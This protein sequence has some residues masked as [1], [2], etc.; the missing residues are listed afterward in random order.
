MNNWK[1]TTSY[2]KDDQDRVPVSWSIMFGKVRLTVT[3]DHIYHTGRWVMIAH[4]FVNLKELNVS[5]ALDAQAEA[6][7]ILRGEV[8]TTIKELETELLSNLFEARRE[9]K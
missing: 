6:I 4:P 2:R 8:L 5:N 7:S 1:D 9:K 3:C